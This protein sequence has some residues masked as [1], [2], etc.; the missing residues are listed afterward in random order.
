MDTVFF[1]I[2]SFTGLF[3]LMTVISMFVVYIFIKQKKYWHLPGSIFLVITFALFVKD[4]ITGSDVAHFALAGV[5][6]ISIIE[7]IVEIRKLS[8][9]SAETEEERRIRKSTTTR[10]VVWLFL[11]ILLVYLI[12]TP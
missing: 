11:K 7:S 9:T 1:S 4:E 2:F 10:G 3:S 12:L 8:K 5:V 6:F